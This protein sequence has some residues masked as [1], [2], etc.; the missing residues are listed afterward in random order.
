MYVLPEKKSLT[1][2]FSP[3]LPANYMN[4]TWDLSMCWAE[5]CCHPGRLEYTISHAV[6]DKDVRL[7]DIYSCTA[8]QLK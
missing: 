1:T 7:Y 8:W 4:Q 6:T 3:F 2:P 5:K